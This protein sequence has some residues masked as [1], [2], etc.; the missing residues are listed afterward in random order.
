[1]ILNRPED[2]TVFAHVM[3]YLVA[4]PSEWPRAKPPAGSPF[5]K[6]KKQDSRTCHQNSEST[7]SISVS[8]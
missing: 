7:S 6:G 8:H 5:Q 2:S 3:F 1:M 4:T